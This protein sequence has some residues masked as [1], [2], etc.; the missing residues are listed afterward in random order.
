MSTVVRCA[1]EVTDGCGTGLDYI[2]ESPLSCFLL[3]KHREEAE[4]RNVAPCSVSVT[5]ERISG[6]VL[7]DTLMKI[8]ADSY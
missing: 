3:Q 6:E 5:N 8:E 1:A 4:R 7:K 2:W